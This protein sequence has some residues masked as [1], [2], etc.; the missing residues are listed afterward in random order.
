MISANEISDQPRFSGLPAD[1]PALEE[2]KRIPQWVAWK[3][4]HRGGPKPT[5]PPINPHNGGYA[6]CDSSATW[7]TYEQAERRARENGLAGVGFVLSEDD[8]LTGFDFDK[9]YTPAGKLKPLAFYLFT[10]PQNLP[11]IHPS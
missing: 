4:E 9:C 1:I 11:H 6:S 10:H 8:N 5:K 3:Y 7:G 2:L